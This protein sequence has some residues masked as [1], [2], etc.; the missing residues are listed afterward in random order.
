MFAPRTFTMERRARRESLDLPGPFNLLGTCNE[1][2]GRGH[3]RRPSCRE[4]LRL[5]SRRRR[6]AFG[7]GPGPGRRRQPDGLRVAIQHLQADRACRLPVLPQCL[8]E[9]LPPA[10]E[11]V[12]AELQEQPKPMRQL[13]SGY[14]V[15]R[16][17]E[18]VGKSLPWSRRSPIFAPAV[19]LRSS[20]DG[21]LVR[22]IAD[23]AP[24]AMARLIP[25]GPL[26]V[27]CQPKARGLRCAMTS[28]DG[29]GES[30]FKTHEE[31]R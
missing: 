28:A 4:T 5:R 27:S 2:I 24:S 7:S 3:G 22:A 8:G 13:D 11:P 31:I 21:P 20:S 9:E 12:A 1:Q 23:V 30:P 15:Q 29:R 6:L 26:R 14:P 10:L 16:M 25:V 17:T 18:G 19:G